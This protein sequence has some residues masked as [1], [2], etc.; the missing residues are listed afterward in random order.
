MEPRAPHSNESMQESPTISEAKQI[1][2]N[3]EENIL[4]EYERTRPTTPGASGN[5]WFECYATILN[6][7][8]ILDFPN[9]EQEIGAPRQKIILDRI[10]E[11]NNKRKEIRSHYTDHSQLPSEEDRAYLLNE[12]KHILD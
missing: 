3:A 7:L 4:G 8:M 9:V 1:L 10:N 11:L 2:V 5:S 6:H 12:L